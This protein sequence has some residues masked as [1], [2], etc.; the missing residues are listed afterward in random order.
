MDL[1]EKQVRLAKVASS[2]PRRVRLLRLAEKFRR[3]AADLAR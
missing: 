1:A 3:Q 2:K